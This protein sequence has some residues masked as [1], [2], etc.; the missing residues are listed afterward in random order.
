VA[1]SV[2]VDDRDGGTDSQEFTIIITDLYVN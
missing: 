1:V 2:T